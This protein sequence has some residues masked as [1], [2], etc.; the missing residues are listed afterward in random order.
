MKYYPL[1]K[2]AL[3]ELPAENAHH[4][5]MKALSIAT[6]IPGFEKMMGNT[7]SEENKLKTEVAGITFPNPIGLA[8][9]FDKNATHITE[10]S[11]LG[12]GF[13]EIGTVTPRPQKGNPKPRLFRLAKDEALI[14]RMG[15]N[16]DGVEAILYRLEELRKKN[17]NIIIGGNIGKNKQTQNDD[18]N[19]DYLK[20]FDRLY[21]FVNYFVLNVSSPNTPGLRALQSKEAL[22]SLL[23]TIMNANAARKHL[24]PVFLKVAPDMENEQLEEILIAAET[25]KIAGIIA[26][27]TTISR[28]GLKSN[29]RLVK[30]IGEGGLS[31][32]PLTTRSQ[33]V[34]DFILKHK[35]PELKV[36]SSGGI[37]TAE[38]AATRLKK[39]AD[40]I[41]IYTGFIYNGP[42]LIG[43]IKRE[44]IK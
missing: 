13:I 17:E 29:H 26:T 5:T 30:A 34:L 19:A 1:L 4:L 20:C 23:R 41:Q 25:N 42:G 8:A 15:F 18:A 27:N 40:L 7:I 39:G 11:K 6:K 9:G 24:K 28:E 36:I 44:L 16:N 33:E 32:K 3:F 10:L 12:F 35:L 31:G 14:N 38:D 37:M 43:N 2:K 22:N 21:P